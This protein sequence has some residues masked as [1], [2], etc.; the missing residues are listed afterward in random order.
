MGRDGALLQSSGS[1]R[2]LGCAQL[3]CYKASCIPAVRLYAQRLF[4]TAL[5]QSWV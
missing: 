5:N 3:I 1:E 4:I 2:F